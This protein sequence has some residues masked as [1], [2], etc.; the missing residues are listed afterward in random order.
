MQ[1]STTQQARHGRARLKAERNQALLDSCQSQVLQ[2]LIGPFG[3]TPAMF[4]DKRGGNVTTQYNASQGIYAKDSEGYDRNKDYKYDAA[5]TEIKRSLV[6]SG[7]MSSQTFLDSYGNRHEPTKQTNAKGKSVMNAE[8]DHLV[9]L[10]EIHRGGGW[11][12]TKEQRDA[13]S[14]EKANLHYTTHKT[15]QAKKTKRPEDFLTEENGFDQS[16]VAPKIERAREA[17]A[18]H[19][20]S[21][22]DRVKYHSHELALTGAPE[23][24]K[25]AL[26]QAIGVVL[27]EV[28][29]GLFVEIK[30]LISTPGKIDRLLERLTAALG[31][32]TERVRLKV[33]ATL[34]AALHGGLQAF[35]SNLLTFLINNLITTSARVVTIIRESMRGLYD[36]AKIL[37]SPPAGMPGIEVAR[38]ST[39]IIAGVVTTVLGMLFE[40]AVSSFLHSI[41]FL[42]PVAGLIS[43]A[44]TGILTGVAASLVIYGID[45]LFDWLASSGTEELEVCI[46]ALEASADLGTKIAEL[47]QQQFVLSESFLDSARTD[48]LI[49][50]AISNSEKAIAEAAELGGSMV[51]SRNETL[52][53]LR[54]W[55]VHMQAADEQV[56]SF[57]ATLAYETNGNN[58]NV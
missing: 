53:A 18:G 2:Q 17:V 40:E 39:K 6:A 47:A 30:E 12:M 11:M 32:I 8:L 35:V 3:L 10:Q 34:D 27:Y 49:A 50:E 45:R 13:V 21:T 52:Q 38:S 48:A 29:N 43:P 20:P 28:V 23:A 42:L 19:M 14:S 58:A 36:A 15:N 56:A 51:R 1:E 7:E 44:I 46:G 4:D 54:H 22:M 16:V 9:P 31:R 37:V 33:S 5:K 57:L 24:A 25:G 41:P 26:R 55:R